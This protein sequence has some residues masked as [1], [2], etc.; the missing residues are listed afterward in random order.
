[1]TGAATGPLP[2]PQSGTRRA[3][4]PEA[5][6]ASTSPITTRWTTKDTAL[7]ALGVGAGSDD[8]AAELA[9]TTDNSEGAPHQVLPTF[10]VV[11]SFPCF[12][13][14]DALDEVGDF[15][16]GMAVHA[17][18]FTE[19]HAPIPPQGAVSTVATIVGVWDKGS[20][21]L[22][23]AELISRNLETG[24]PLFT[25]RNAIFIKGAGGWGGDRGPSSR[26]GVPDGTPDEIVCTAT[27]PDQALLYRL[28][29][30]VNPLHSDPVYARRFGLERPILHGLCTYGFTCRTL[31]H[32]VCGSDASRFRS[33]GGRFT[34]PVIP[35][36]ELTIQIWRAGAGLAHYRT[37]NQHGAAV[38]D[39]GR[40]EYL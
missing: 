26:D 21:A 16:R 10:A 30:D 37:I 29:G 4:N 25:N 6:G 17:Y 14:G 32:A 3:V 38:I 5:V 28:S 11:P 2:S 27:R 40:F 8:P 1:M 36:D 20:G 13:G 23:E 24:A 33:M 18:Q 15:D 35:G 7:Y 12:A 19:L 34:A 31:L 9:F 22:V 39:A